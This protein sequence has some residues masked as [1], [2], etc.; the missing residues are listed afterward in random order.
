MMLINQLANGNHVSGVIYDVEK[1]KVGTHR[2]K[3]ITVRMGSTVL[4]EKPSPIIIA[5]S[6]MVKL[7]G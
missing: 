1:M 3:S 5:Q 6:G 4:V 7:K 2:L